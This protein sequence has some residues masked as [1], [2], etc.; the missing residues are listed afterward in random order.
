[1]TKHVV[2]NYIPVVGPPVFVHT[3]LLDPAKLSVA[4]EEFVAMKHL[5]IV[6]H[7]NSARAS[8]ITWCPN[9]TGGGGRAGIFGV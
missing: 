7:L 6:Q 2:K 3:H 9:Q 4:Q 8:P 1:M 5:G